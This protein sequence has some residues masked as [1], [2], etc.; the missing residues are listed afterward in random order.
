[1]NR[2]PFAL[3]LLALLALA[4]P[5]GSAHAVSDSSPPTLVSISLSPLSVDVTAAAAT[6]A[7][8]YEVADDLSGARSVEVRVGPA[9]G[10]ACA[11][12]VSVATAASFAP[13]TSR[14][15]T[16]DLAI[17]LHAPS[18]TWTVCNVTVADAT[19]N[20]VTLG[21]SDIEL[22]GGVHDF[23]VLSD[24]D[25]SPPT[26]VAFGPLPASVDTTSGNTSFD[27][28]AS[29]TDDLSGIVTVTPIVG[30]AESGECTGSFTSVL[31]N[32]VAPPALAYGTAIHFEI[33]AFHPA[34]T[35]AI[36][37]IEL[38]DA[39]GNASRLDTSDLVALGFPT[40]FEV[41][42]TTDS[43]PPT[44]TGFGLSPLAVDTDDAAA[45]I[46][47]SWSATDDLSGV[48]RAF[49]LIAPAGCSG[50]YQQTSIREVASSNAASDSFQVQVPRWS[51][52]GP[53]EVCA[54]LVVDGGGNYAFLDATGLAAAGWPSG[55]VNSVCGDGLA[56]SNETCDD[57]AA[58]GTEAS[59]CSTS[60]Q[61]VAAGT[62][63]T[64]DADPCTTDA[65]TAGG[66]CEHPSNG[67][68]LSSRS[69]IAEVGP[70]GG[71][72]V[73]PDGSVSLV[74]PA[75]A[76]AA[77]TQV[78]LKGLAAPVGAQ[79]TGAVEVGPP[80]LAFLASASLSLSWSD[81][82]GDGN[83]DGLQPL[84]RESALSV[85]RDGTPVTDECRLPAHRPE[86]CST[87]CCDQSA[88]RWTVPTTGAGSFAIV[89]NG[90][91]SGISAMRLTI[92]KLAAPVGDETIAWQG[93]LLLPAE[94][95]STFD[96][97]STGLRLQLDDG[98]ETVLDVL[99]P[100]SKWIANRAVTVWKFTPGKS[101][102]APAGIGTMVLKADKNVAGLVKFVVKGKN[103][104]YTVG[105]GLT[106]R[107]L[108]DQGACFAAG[109]G[110]P[111]PAPS[112]STVGTK[113]LCR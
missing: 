84:V 43:T 60:C 93:D 113:V 42:A 23:T 3:P 64:A 5:A 81:A 104:D 21:P 103:A 73:V 35:W 78:V 83:V 48:R 72:V 1:M 61:L 65:C 58:N 106:A 7:V 75:G 80:G 62:A 74:V 15:G 90:C 69:T 101:T 100:A 16:I 55:F 95:A 111:P 97:R 89:R 28:P 70:A 44:I 59:C 112:C 2:R 27:V 109:P 56:T 67:E 85:S 107:I 22:L 68:C 102:P 99:L 57:G 9:V 38:R 37:E 10:G 87:A 71:T 76:V 31:E 17:P 88:N 24:P 98:I 53:W 33:P 79:V 46:D 8:A 77:P 66:S 14:S 47:V 96:P 25:T 18:G 92:G 12:D 41:L 51:A 29:V 52:E 34:G 54:L 30:P 39:V 13:S 94:L 50:S 19:G 63:C 36:C 20:S 11:G 6:L 32:V 91:D 45:T 4:P 105:S 40:T 82:N 108:V 86:T 49:V 26:L 110:S